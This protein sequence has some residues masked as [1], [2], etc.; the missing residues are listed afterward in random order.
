MPSSILPDSAMRSKS[1]P[2]RH[3]SCEAR[4]AHAA[5]KPAGGRREAAERGASGA[6]ANHDQVHSLLVEVHLRLVERDD[7]RVPRYL[8]VRRHLLHELRKPPRDRHDLDSIKLTRFEV[9]CYS[10]HATRACPQGTVLHELILAVGR[11]YL[12][13]RRPL[14]HEHLTPAAQTRTC[15]SALEEAGCPLR[16]GAHAE[17]CKHLGEKQG[18]VY[19]DPAQVTVTVTRRGHPTRAIARAGTRSSA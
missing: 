7:V 4:H 19:N 11:V 17:T 12:L 3:S 1:S 14:L 18:T 10:D 5:E 13:R 8:P 6:G 2:P 15:P 16:S 9:L